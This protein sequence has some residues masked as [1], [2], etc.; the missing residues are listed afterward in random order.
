LKVRMEM[1]DA[2]EVDEKVHVVVIHQCRMRRLFTMCCRVFFCLG[3]GE[4]RG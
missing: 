3:V 2:D 4:V 1:P